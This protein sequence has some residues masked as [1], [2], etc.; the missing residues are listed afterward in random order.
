MITIKINNISRLIKMKIN[1]LPTITTRLTTINTL[2]RTKMINNKTISL[3]DNTLPNPS[4][5]RIR[6]S[7][8]VL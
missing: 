7:D 8:K 1:L 4:I 2:I 3:I 6:K 5:L